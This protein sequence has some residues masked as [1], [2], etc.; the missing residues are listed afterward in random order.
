M[1]DVDDDKYVTWKDLSKLCSDI[2]SLKAQNKLIVVL[3]SSN[4]LLNAYLILTH[5]IP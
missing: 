5:L 3:L 4:I 1:S 2:A